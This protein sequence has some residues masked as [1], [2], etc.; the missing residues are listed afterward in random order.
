MSVAF[1]F[2]GFRSTSLAVVSF[3]LNSH[4]RGAVH[5]WQTLPNEDTVS[6]WWYRAWSAL[7]TCIALS[8]LWTATGSAKNRHVEPST[9]FT[10]WNET[11]RD[12]TSLNVQLPH[13]VI[14][15]QW[16]LFDTF[17]GSFINP[18]LSG[19]TGVFLHVRCIPH[20]NSQ[21]LFWASVCLK[22]HHLITVKLFLRFKST[23]SHTDLN[24]PKFPHFL[25]MTLHKQANLWGPSVLHFW[26]EPSCSDDIPHL[27][28]LALFNFPK[29][30]WWC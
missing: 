5:D 17:S 18:F 24:I 9:K 28:A 16:K 22:L 6:S 11:P 14:F 4:C 23:S 25:Y 10:F 19:I 8:F 12:V 15:W 30:F 3:L 21:R 29:L 27:L 7:R 20:Q 2:F 13:S 1:A 26:M